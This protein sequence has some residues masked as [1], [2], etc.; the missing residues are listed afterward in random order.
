MLKRQLWAQLLKI[1]Y[2]RDIESDALWLQHTYLVVVAKC[3]A[4]AVLGLNEDDPVRLLSGEALASAGVNGAVES[5]F[6]D[7]IV[8]DPEGAKLVRRMMAHVRR[9]RLGEVESDVM[10]TLYESLIDREQRH[11]L[12][13][14]YTP[15]WLAAKMARH[16]IDRPLEQKVLDPAC[17]SG[18]FLFHAIRLFLAEAEESGTPRELRATDGARTIAG[19]D[20][21][22]VAVIIARVTYLLALAPALAARS[23]RLTIPVYLGDTMRLAVT[24][25]FA[26]KTL[27]I[28][29]PDTDGAPPTNLHFPSFFAAI[30]NCSTTRLTSYAAPRRP[31]SR[32]AISDSNRGRDQ[33]VLFPSAQSLP[34]SDHSRVRR[35]RGARRH[36][37]RRNYLLYD[38]LRRDGRD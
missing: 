1:V 5:D 20:I 12:G 3:V 29:V 32:A 35:R 33:S 6:F 14:Y 11:G 23:G 26:D 30:Q 38:R 4:F 17:G 13:E 36:R 10:K 19:V 18:T 9:F 31:A 27:T 37:H 7:W 2:G 16:A 34:R 25:H 15:D 21:H 24:Q 28:R 22:P 8:A